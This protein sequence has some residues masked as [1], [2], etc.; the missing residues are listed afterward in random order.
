MYPPIRT[1]GNTCD[2]FSCGWYWHLMDKDILG[3][4][5]QW[6]GAP[7]GQALLHPGGGTEQCVCVSLAEKTA[8]HMKTNLVVA[9]IAT[10]FITPNLPVKNTMFFLMCQF[11]AKIWCEMPEGEEG[12][13]EPGR[14]DVHTNKAPFLHKN[15]GIKPSIHMLT[16][17]KAYFGDG[18]A[19]DHIL[20]ANITHQHLFFQC[21]LSCAKALV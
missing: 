6:K 16:T 13:Q 17:T 3:E 9:S 12:N 19:C 8:V 7:E 14:R 21:S 15:V 4:L 18:S 10:A 5:R 20:R 1:F 2:S 11:N